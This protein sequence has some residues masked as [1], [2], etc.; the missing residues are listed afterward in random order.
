[1]IPPAGRT[2]GAKYVPMSVIVPTVELPPTIPFTSHATAVFE[3]PVTVAE[4]P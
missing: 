1:M 3:V 4:N 2:L